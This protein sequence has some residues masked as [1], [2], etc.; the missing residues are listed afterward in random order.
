MSTPYI[1]HGCAATKIVAPRLEIRTLMK[2]DENHQRQFSLFIQAMHMLMNSKYTPAAASWQEIGGIHGVP[3]SRWGGD[4][5]GPNSPVA[6]SWAGY[7]FHASVLFPTW[8]RVLLL[9][10]E[11]S[12]NEAAHK[13]II[14]NSNRLSPAEHAKWEQSAN[15]LRFPFWDWTTKVEENEGLPDVFKSKTVEILDWNGQK[16]VY[17]P[18][19]LESFPFNH[20]PSGAPETSTLHFATWKRTYRWVD[21][22]SKDII[23]NPTQQYDK[24]NQALVGTAHENP[25]TSKNIAALRSKLHSMFTYPVHDENTKNHSLYWNNFSNIGDGSNVGPPR[26]QHASL[27]DPHNKMHL[28]IG[29]NGDMSFNEMAGFDPLFYFHHC[30]I[31]RL[32]ALW[33][34]IYPD[35]WMGNG[36]T[37]SRNHVTP[38]K[39]GDGSYQLGSKKAVTEKT[40]LA[41]FRKGDGSHYWNSSD[42]RGLQQGHGVNK[43]YSYEPLEV[44]YPDRTV[45]IDISKPSSPREREIYCAALQDLYSD[46]SNVSSGT[47]QP[48]KAAFFKQLPTSVP[49]DKYEAARGL[50]EFVVIAHVAQYIVKSS[51]H[52]EL[53][54]DGTLVNEMSVLNR[55]VPERCENCSAREHQPGGAQ[56]RVPMRL[57]HAAVVHVLSKY[58]L[59]EEH[60]SK[61]EI[62][63]VLKERL[64]SRIVGP[65]RNLLIGNENYHAAHP[66]H[67]PA[68]AGNHIPEEKN[69]VLELYSTQILHPKA[70]HGHLPVRCGELHGHG[71]VHTGR[72]R[73]AH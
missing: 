58:H 20:V 35:Y 13:V 41:P 26:F 38:F 1:I 68:S 48:A 53:Y 71:K 69:P 66:N 18:N 45:V 63:K 9:A 33:E 70:E 4:P 17:S 6:N 10:I 12:M 34:H 73:H 37:D 49:N 44:K 23:H 30:N 55:L 19:P 7:C 2:D 43:Y 60:T 59:N 64:T 5:K 72:W 57:P 67:G 14:G 42:V 24:L 27:E 22:R 21:S 29:G 16:R 50:H 52:L 56:V 39:D 51:Y 15:E 40:D 62:I 61:E 65:D 54:L 46:S 11:Q 31:D 32:Y 8:H 28:D 47:T 25:S 36:W 3:Y